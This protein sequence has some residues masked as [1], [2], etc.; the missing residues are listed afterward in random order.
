M[1][2]AFIFHPFLS[3]NKY[4][5]S[6]NSTIII[7]HRTL[8]SVP[9]LLPSREQKAKLVFFGFECGRN[10]GATHKFLISFQH[11]IFGMR[12][13]VH[14]PIKW[15][16]RNLLNLPES[17]FHL[18]LKILYE[19]ERQKTQLWTFCLNRKQ[20]DVNRNE[21]FLS[22]P[23]NEFPISQINTWLHRRRAE[24]HPEPCFPHNIDTRRRPLSSTGFP[25]SFEQAT[26]LPATTRYSVEMCTNIYGFHRA[27]LFIDRNYAT[28]AL[29]R[30][31][32]CWWNNNKLTMGIEKGFEKLDFLDETEAVWCDCVSVELILKL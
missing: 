21:I 32:A 5:E 9:L 15:R 31:Y 6:S 24:R 14:F 28:K 23:Q 12:S 2:W 22:H 8:H 7:S 26:K 20:I 18:K 19:I 10:P 1:L 27:L 17:L 11:W 4:R 30:V 25:S 13:W 29:E 3:L 16:G